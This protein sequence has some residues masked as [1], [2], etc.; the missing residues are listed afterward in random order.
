MQWSIVEQGGRRMGGMVFV[1]A[2]A[3]DDVDLKA[4]AKMALKFVRTL[5]SK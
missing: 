4:I 3:C 1:D 2:D 5:P